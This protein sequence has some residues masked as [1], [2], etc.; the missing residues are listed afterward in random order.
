M[1]SKKN[2]PSEELEKIA[3]SEGM[4]TLKMDGI[5][6]IFLGATDIIQIKSVCF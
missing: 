3:L 2:L 5:H 1:A 6:K 4:R